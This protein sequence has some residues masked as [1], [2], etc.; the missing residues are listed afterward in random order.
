MAGFVGY[1]KPNRGGSKMCK[2]RRSKAGLAA[3]LTTLAL[4]ITTSG[5]LRAVEPGHEAVLVK[6]PVFSATAASTR[7]Q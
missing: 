5:C 2:T 6:K 4:L 3:V 1:A 7:F